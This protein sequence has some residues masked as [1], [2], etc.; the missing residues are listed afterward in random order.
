MITVYRITNNKNG[1]L[2]FGV[3]R[4]TARETK[5]FGASTAGVRAMVRM[6][7]NELYPREV[8]ANV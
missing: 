5:Q 3:T 7:P 1:K 8:S 2:Y 4:R 6:L